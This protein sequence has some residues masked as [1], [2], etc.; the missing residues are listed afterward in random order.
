MDREFASGASGSPPTHPASPS[1]GY[2]TSGN[3]GSGTPAT[4]P[5][6][7]WYHMINEEIR[8]VL[9]AAGI[10]PDGANTTQLVAA[11][12][13]LISGSQSGAVQGA[14]KKLAASATGT[15][16][17]VTVSA[18]EVVVESAGAAFKTLASVA[19]SINS[20][21]AGANGLDTGAL[22]ANSWYS[23]WVIWNGTTVAGLL[24]LSATAPTLPGGYTHKAR[25]GWI[26]TDGSGNK[27]PLSFK[28]AGRHVQYAV[29]SGTNVT[30]P[31]TMASGVSGTYTS[32]TYTGTAVAVAN[33][34]PPT[35]SRIALTLQAGTSGNAAAASPST[36]Y[37]GYGGAAPPPIQTVCAANGIICISGDFMIES[38]NIYYA[39]VA[40]ANALQ[41][42][43][44]EDNL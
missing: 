20:A 21:A 10:T 31:P 13:A 8:N 24:S 29:A 30:A 22:A 16:A 18:D 37:T 28:Q 33:F 43:G 3:P 41:C 35:A 9:V 14:F 38:S 32:G 25:L 15:N 44:W 11:I 42:T 6:P 7:W 1:L 34:V 12:Q 4:K 2:P 39:G 19:L 17:T 23:V 5:G 26:R 36:A 27:Y 40:A